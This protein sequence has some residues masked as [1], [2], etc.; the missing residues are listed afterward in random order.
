MIFT[1]CRSLT[2][3]PLLEQ[4]GSHSSVSAPILTDACLCSRVTHKEA[5]HHCSSRWSGPH[6]VGRPQRGV[7]SGVC[8]HSL[9]K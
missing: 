1:A 9:W 7:R 4:A 5:A 3:V 8:L 2:K 6:R